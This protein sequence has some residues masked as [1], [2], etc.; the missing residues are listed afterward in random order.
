M[1]DMKAPLPANIR[2]A[3]DYHMKKYGLPP[4]IVE[5][6]Y[7]LSGLS[8]VDGVEFVP[9]N[10]PTNILLIGVKDEKMGIP[11]EIQF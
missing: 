5:H 9:V 6:S 8:N 10:I 2:Q 7:K 1:M 3:L 11:L 4:N